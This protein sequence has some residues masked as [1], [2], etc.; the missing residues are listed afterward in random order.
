MA[1]LKSAKMVLV[2]MRG[3]HAAADLLMQAFLLAAGYYQHHGEWRFR[4]GEAK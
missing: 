1:W 4:N 2:Q 3:Q